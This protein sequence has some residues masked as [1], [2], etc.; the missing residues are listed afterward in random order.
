M[1]LK[2]ETGIVFA[3][4]RLYAEYLKPAHM[5]DALVV[6]TQ[7][8]RLGGASIEFDQRVL[9]GSDLLFSAEV[10]VA[11]LSENGRPSRISNSLREALAK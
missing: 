6:Q 8:S 1:A 4:R 2:N 5:D 7:I 3:V 10:I 11:A 9:R